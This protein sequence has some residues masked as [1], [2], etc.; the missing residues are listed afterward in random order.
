MSHNTKRLSRVK[1]VMVDGGYRGEPFAN[2]VK[3]ILGET[4]TTEVAKRD[5]L[6]T[7]KVIPKRW[8]VERSFAWLEKNRRLWKNCERHLNSS[9][10]FTNLAFIALLLKRL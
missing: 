1:N 9:L 4:V 7:F 6:Q 10:Q 5:E 3:S 2:S 8:V